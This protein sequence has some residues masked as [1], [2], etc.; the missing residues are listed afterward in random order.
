MRKDGRELRLPSIMPLL[1][2]VNIT[3]AAN[4]L[5][6]HHIQQQHLRHSCTTAA[7]V[8]AIINANCGQATG[9]RE[10]FVNGV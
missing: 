4:S 8:P 6:L 10:S 7:L 1:E 2:L 3:R 9:V 5:A